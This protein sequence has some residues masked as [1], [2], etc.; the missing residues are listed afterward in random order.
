MV[1]RG[2]STIASLFCG[3]QESRFQLAIAGA[4]ANRYANAAPA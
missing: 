1:I 2:C 3:S 4:I